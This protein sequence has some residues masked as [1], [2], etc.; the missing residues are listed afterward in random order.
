[1]FERTGDSDQTID[2]MV[3]GLY[4]AVITVT[5]VGYGDLLP[6]TWGGRACTGM[7]AMIGCA[8]FALPVG[9][10]GSGFALQVEQERQD[11]RYVYYLN[12]CMGPVFS[13]PSF[14]ESQFFK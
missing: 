14:F 5:S 12:R 11:K 4:W 6:T 8:F 10:L 7:L 3:N 2:D 9:I 1:M 13:F